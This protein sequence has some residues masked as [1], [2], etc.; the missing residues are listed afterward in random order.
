MSELSASSGGSRGVIHDL[1]YR[2]YE[3]VRL[4]RFQIARALS[5][6][7]FRSAFG[8][9]RGVKAKVVP[10]ITFVLICLPAVVN[11]VLVATGR[12]H[13]RQ[14]NYDTY[15]F[16]LRRLD[17]PLAKLAAFIAACLAMVEIPLLLLYLGTIVS[18]S[19]PG[20]V[21]DET[22]ALTA[23]LLVGLMWATLLAV[24]GLALASL[25]ARRAY[26]TGAIAIYFFLSL[27]LAGILTRIARTAGGPLFVTGPTT[28]ARLS[29]LVSPFTVLDGVR[30]WLGG[31]S[32]GPVPDLGPYGP[33]YGLMFLALVA[34]G[35]AVLFARYRK[36]GVA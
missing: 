30:R 11:A 9:G 24:I 8:L 1:G 35:L 23:G 5:W 31:T 4:G 27:S 29:G 18:A 10:V 25:S 16:Q 6:H 33:V 36:V 2:R 13:T 17:Y 28:G 22:K 20:A 26:A 14:I 3:G 15:I 21:W 32:P 34:A 12:N 19:G 7:S